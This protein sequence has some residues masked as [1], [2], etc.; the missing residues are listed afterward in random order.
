M[1]V[2]GRVVLLDGCDVVCFCCVW[3]FVCV[4]VDLFGL[5]CCLFRCPFVCM[6]SFACL[7]VSL[8]LVCCSF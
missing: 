3:L 4:F 5:L 8:F 7:F 2:C 6:C 1:L